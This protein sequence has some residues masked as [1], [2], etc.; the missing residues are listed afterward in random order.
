MKGEVPMSFQTW[1]SY[2]IN[3]VSAIVSQYFKLGSLDSAQDKQVKEWL[4]VADSSVDS[5][6]RKEYY[7]KALK[8][9]AEEAYWLPLFSYNSNYVFSQD[10]EYAPTTDAIPRFF[11]MSWK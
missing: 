2:S 1:G 3:D 11:Q 10:L 9:I 7:S 5:E 6:E 8:K 4:D